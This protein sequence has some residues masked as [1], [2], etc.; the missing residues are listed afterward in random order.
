[1]DP[2]D[3]D[4]WRSGNPWDPQILPSAHDIHNAP[5]CA[6]AC[7]W[8]AYVYITW[9][10]SGENRHHVMHVHTIAHHVHAMHRMQLMVYM[11]MWMW[12]LPHVITSHVH[13]MQ[14]IHTQMH[15]MYTCCAH[16]VYVYILTCIHV[17]IYYC[18]EQRAHMLSMLSMYIT[19][20]RDVFMVDIMGF[21][22]IHIMTSSCITCYS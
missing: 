15:R 3:L 12:V 1:M 2:Q 10:F 5:S 18:R 8:R 4:I 17:D 11:V 22:D 9:S 7:T 19:R 13:M 16:D 14:Q 21:Q 6:S 20:C